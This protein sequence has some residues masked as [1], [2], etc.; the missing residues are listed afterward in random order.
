MAKITDVTIDRKIDQPALNAFGKPDGSGNTISIATI[1]FTDRDGTRRV[2]LLG[3]HHHISG[4]HWTDLSDSELISAI[5]TGS[6][7]II[8]R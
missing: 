1:K 7:K 5:E 8:R 3:K 4:R 6:L 2:T